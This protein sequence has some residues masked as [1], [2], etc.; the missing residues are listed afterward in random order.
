MR[1]KQAA[2]KTYNYIPGRGNVCFGRGGVDKG[3]RSDI[4]ILTKVTFLKQCWT[5]SK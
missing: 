5:Q 1:V 3:Y 2:R 4:Q